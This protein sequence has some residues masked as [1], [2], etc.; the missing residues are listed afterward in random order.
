[1]V[2]VASMARKGQPKIQYDCVAVKSPATQMTKAPYPA[3]GHAVAIVTKASAAECG[4][5]A[6]RYLAQGY[7]M[8][9]VTCAIREKDCAWID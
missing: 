2:A 5:R 7:S 4:I 3:A 8:E 6:P 1:M 9:D